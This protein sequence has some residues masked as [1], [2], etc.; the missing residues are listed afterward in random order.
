MEETTLNID[1][2]VYDMSINPRFDI[3]QITIERY[4][5]II[6]EMPPLDVFN[7]AGEGYLLAAGFHRYEAHKISGHEIAPCII[8]QGNKQA[9]IDFADRSNAKNP[10]Q[11]KPEELNGVC[12]R[13]LK[14]DP[15]IPDKVLR[16]EYGIP[17]RMIQDYRDK[18]NWEDGSYLASNGD[19]KES[20]PIISPYKTERHWSELHFSD[21]RNRRPTTLYERLQDCTMCQWPISV[22]AHILDV[23]AWG[24]NEFTTALCVQ[25]HE[26]YDMLVKLAEDP[27]SRA[28]ILIAK[29]EDHL[30]DERTEWYED[31]RKWAGEMVEIRRLLHQEKQRH[32]FNWKSHDTKAAPYME[33]AEN[34][35][36]R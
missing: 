13:A 8:H 12:L 9:A 35:G 28:K 23:A 24:D 14:N 10:L 15:Q 20:V 21:A 36:I 29:L 6:D 17:Q 34:E 5:G 26:I 30:S 7:V 32:L 3:D 19:L 11:L 22:R 1:L 18:I 2:I 31:M 16:L 25:C 27:K 33:M 4:A